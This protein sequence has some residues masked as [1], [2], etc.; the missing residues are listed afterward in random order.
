MGWQTTEPK[1]S[2]VEGWTERQRK[3]T[4]QK[5]KATQVVEKATQSVSERGS[6]GRTEEDGGTDRMAFVEAAR[7][8]DGHARGQT[9][10]QSRKP[11]V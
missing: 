9:V 3:G 1:K 11:N 10:T 7:Q 4:Q 2:R 5:R 6:A 8:D